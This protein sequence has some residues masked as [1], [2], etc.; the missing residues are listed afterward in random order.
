[1]L[2]LSLFHISL[3]LMK[4]RLVVTMM[5]VISKVRIVLMEE[6]IPRWVEAHPP[7]HLI[8]TE[9]QNLRD[10]MQAHPQLKE[11]RRNQR[12][13]VLLRRP[14]HTH[15]LHF[16]HHSLRCIH[17]TWVNSRSSLQQTLRNILSDFQYSRVHL[18]RT[19]AVE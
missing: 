2:C 8:A 11:H 16:N 3:I 19:T 10:K 7:F 5:Q 18:M 12:D 6:S 14:S 15:L 1:M 9:T 13:L 4:Q 17:T